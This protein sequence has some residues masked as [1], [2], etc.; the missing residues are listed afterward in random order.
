MTKPAAFNCEQCGKRL[1]K[2][3][4]RLINGRVLCSPYMWKGPH[5]Q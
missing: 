2:K 3:S 5:K 4:A 1:S